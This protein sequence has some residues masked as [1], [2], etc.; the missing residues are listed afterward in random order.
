MF[1]PIPLCIPI[2]TYYNN[3]TYETNAASA[4][5]AASQYTYESAR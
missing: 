3:V 1:L 5:N 4:R 2:Y